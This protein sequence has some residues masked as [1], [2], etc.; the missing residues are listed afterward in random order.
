MEAD[1]ESGVIIAEVSLVSYSMSV[2]YDSTIT[3]VEQYEM[4]QS[5]KN[6]GVTK[7]IRSYQ[8]NRQ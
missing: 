7:E 8:V 5:G 2:K 6:R 3:I 1:A 4:N